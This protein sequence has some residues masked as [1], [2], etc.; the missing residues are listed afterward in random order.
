[1]PSGRPVQLGRALY[2]KGDFDFSEWGD[3]GQME[4]QEDYQ[5]CVRTSG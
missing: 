4:V 5:I 1:V 2:E 3:E